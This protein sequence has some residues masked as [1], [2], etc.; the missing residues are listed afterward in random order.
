MKVGRVVRGSTTNLY[1]N[2]NTAGTS[3]P[4]GGS[5]YFR[6]IRDLMSHK[7]LANQFKSV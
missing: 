1:D 6:L 7:I 4:H 5:A 2:S 3:H